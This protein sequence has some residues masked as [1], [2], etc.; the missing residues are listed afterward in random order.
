MAGDVHRRSWTCDGHTR[1]RK[2]ERERERERETGGRREK[3]EK[4][5]E[6]VSKFTCTH[7]SN[8]S[9]IQIHDMSVTIVTIDMNGRE[10]ICVKVW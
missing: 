7:K 9:Q 5:R 6:R 10:S 8:G 2:R 4:E 1:E 3:R